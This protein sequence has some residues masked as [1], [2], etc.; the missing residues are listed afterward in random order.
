MYTAL[1]V[2]V[3]H[4]SIYRLIGPVL[5]LQGDS[6]PLI[7][8][9]PK[10]KKMQSQKKGLVAKAGDREEKNTGNSHF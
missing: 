6:F 3:L 9:S 4:I 2:T 1:F 7:G 8:A 10:K 5:S